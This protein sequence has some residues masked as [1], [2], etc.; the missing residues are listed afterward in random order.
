MRGAV[1]TVIASIADLR[2]IV[3]PERSRG[4]AISFFF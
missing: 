2:A 3:C 4:E 1:A